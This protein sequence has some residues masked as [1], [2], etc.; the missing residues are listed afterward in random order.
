MTDTDIYI[1]TGTVMDTIT[2]AVITVM[3]EIMTGVMTDTV[4]EAGIETM[5]ETVTNIVMDTVIC[6]VDSD[7]YSN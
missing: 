5:I 4:T 7:R 2:D 1:V 3:I 6:T